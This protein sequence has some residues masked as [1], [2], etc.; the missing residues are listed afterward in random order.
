MKKYQ[1]NVFQ[2]MLEEIRKKIF[3]EARKMRI[4]NKQVPVSGKRLILPLEGRDID[5][6]YYPSKSADSPLIIGFHGGGFLFGGCALNDG[7]WDAIRN[8][9]DVNVASIEYR[10]SPEYMYKEALDDAYDSVVYMKEHAN[11][12]SFNPEHLS[13]I[14][15]SAG[16]T[17]AATVCLYAKE[18]GGVTF[19]NQIL[20]YPFLDCYTDPMSKGEGSL[21]GPIMYIFNELHCKPEESKLALVSPVF[22]DSVMLKGLPKATICYAQN[23]NL[24]A[25]AQK[26]AGMLR[27]AG[28]EVSEMLGKEMPHGYFE[29]GFGETSEGEYEY[30]GE[31]VIAMIKD[32]TIPLVSRES[33]EFIAQEFKR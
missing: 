26:Y 21:S 4:M 5:I 20:M 14:G 18:K 17:L 7:V 16:G 11:E 23:D 28:V 8:R 19:D 1:K 12:F 3:E 13:V 27:S 29:C 10:K 25:E 24:R 15:C 6:V 32:G 22:A 31:E 30:L 9:L 33:L 2:D